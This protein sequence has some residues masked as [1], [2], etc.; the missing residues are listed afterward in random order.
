M[1]VLNTNRRDTVVYNAGFEYKIGPGKKAELPDKIAR[2]IMRRFP[3]V[4]EWVSDKRQK[5]IATKNRFERLKAQREK[6]KAVQPVIE[7]AADN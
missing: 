3:C 2:D 1:Q 7:L 5:E 6:K 4:E